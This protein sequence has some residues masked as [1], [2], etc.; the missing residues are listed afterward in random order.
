MTQAEVL[1]RIAVFL[2]PGHSKVDSCEGRFV[3]SW[4]PMNKSSHVFLAVSLESFD[5]AFHL[6]IKTCA[7]EVLAHQARNRAKYRR[8][9]EEEGGY[10]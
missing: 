1:D 10:Q 5:D 2:P 7:R 8:K 3:A 9:G 6:L 4:A